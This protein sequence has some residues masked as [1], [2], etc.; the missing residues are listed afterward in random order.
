MVRLTFTVQLAQD[1]RGSKS[2]DHDMDKNALSR[3]EF[4]KFCFVLV[5]KYLQEQG[6]EGNA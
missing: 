6:S 3:Y 5:Q 4:M 1:R 2:V